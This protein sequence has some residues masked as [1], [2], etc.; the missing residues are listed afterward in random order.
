MMLGLQWEGASRVGSRLKWVL[1]P[2]GWLRSIFGTM[3]AMKKLHSTQV[4]RRITERSGRG[5]VCY[6]SSYSYLSD[7]SF[8]VVR[9]HLLGGFDRIWID[10]L[11]GDSRETGKRTPEGEPDPSVF[12]TPFNREGIRLGT[13]VG[14]FVRHGPTDGQAEVRYRQFWGTRKR[15]DL[16]ETLANG[17]LEAGYEVTSPTAA[18]RYNFRP[19]GPAS[20]YDAWP[21]FIALAEAE[22]FSG[23]AEMRRGSL[24]E[25][26]R[27]RLAERM[28]RYMDP[29]ISFDTLKGEGIGPVE[30]AGAFDPERARERLLA[31]EAFDA[32]KII[33]FTSLPLDTRFAYHTNVSPIWNRA[34][35]EFFAAAR[36]GNRFLVSRMMAERPQEGVP[37]LPIT[38]LPDYHLLR[39]NI[40]AFP[41]RLLES[42]APQG[43]LLAAPARR[44]NLSARTRAWLAT[45][46][47]RDPDTDHDLGDSPWY[48]A[49]AMTAS[50]AWL[51]ENQ[52]A[53][54]GGWPRVPLPTDLM[55]LETSAGLGRQIAALLDT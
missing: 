54:L 11:N 47:D 27:D 45:L 5:I 19:L 9:R 42:N 4:K 25:T 20:N 3:P 13:A 23:L 48:Y 31:R 14:M 21:D 1:Q 8:V 49:L 10:S 12:S 44:A 32:T 16:V 29:S 35:P 22:P 17:T 30:E 50:P 39:P 41:F 33:R 7:P 51:E 52:A 26:D 34:R 40:R 53:I 2:A 43:D 18:N 28:Q 6:V 46:T 37:V 15:E 36:D 38:A 55:H 24:I